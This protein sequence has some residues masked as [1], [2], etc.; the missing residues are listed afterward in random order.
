MANQ[1]LVNTA[2]E[3]LREPNIWKINFQLNSLLVTGHRFSMVARAIEQGSISIKKADLN[4]AT[5]SQRDADRKLTAAQYRD[6]HTI[7]VPHTGYG[8]AANDTP[9]EKNKAAHEKSVIIHEATHAM[10]D[11][12]APSKD[13]RTL[14]VHDETSAILAQAFYIKLG[15]HQ[16]AKHDFI[17][18]IDGSGDHALNLVENVVNEPGY[19]PNSTY[20]FKDSLRLQQLQNA[21]RSDYDLVVKTDKNG[22]ISDS[23]NAQYIYNGVKCSR[24]W[25]GG[26]KFNP[27]DQG[28]GVSAGS[29]LRSGTQIN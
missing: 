11:L 6:D 13:Y 21:V 4:S 3:V 12:F 10:F 14:I 8:Q 18:R 20:I 7:Y 22:F 16:D 15:D 29:S 28:Q 1:D 2:L 17:R 26:D 25:S 24:C 27:Y 5:P 19:S 23:R 9:I